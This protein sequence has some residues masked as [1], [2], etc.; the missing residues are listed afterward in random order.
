VTRKTAYIFLLFALVSVGPLYGDDRGVSGQ[1]FFRSQG[2]SGV[3]V[4]AFDL[5]GDS[6]EAAGA[7]NTGSDGR[8]H[9]PLAPGSYRITARK[10]PEG[11]GSGGML[12]ASTGDNPVI[13][14]S[15]TLEL[16]PLNLTDSGGAGSAGV[17][18]TR[19]TGTVYSDGEP[20]AGAYV[21]FYPGSVRR[22]P[23]YVARARTGQ[24]GRY[25]AALSPGSYT[26]TVRFGWS[27]DGMGAVD[28]G[29][30]VA[31]YPGSPVVVGKD[32]LDLGRVDTRPV[33][34]ESWEKNRWA[35]ASATIT[36]EGVVSDENRLPV[37]GA[38]A[39]L[40]ADYRMVGKPSAISPPTGKDGRYSLSVDDPGTYYLGA[41]TRFGGPVEPGEFMGAW[42][43]DTATPLVLETGSP[44]PSRDIVVR[45]VW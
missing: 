34:P 28:V 14:S 43:G 25:K 38:Y 22:G 27:G 11:P 3:Y 39:F 6:S 23:G 33:D 24:G 37:A 9:I 45:E 35:V 31:E 42:G 20:L 2:L 17:G 30:L 8:F 1:T 7:A 41:R 21:Y 15:G 4:E 5:S 16:P 40:Y 18:E 19:I 10:R 13:V 26:V 44:S 29:D 12:F 36:V 32:A